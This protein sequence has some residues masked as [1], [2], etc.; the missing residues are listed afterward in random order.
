[1]KTT[2]VKF[3]HGLTFFFIIALQMKALSLVDFKKMY[4]YTKV[5]LDITSNGHQMLGGSI[6][7]YNS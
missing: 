7:Y 3:D 2:L 6:T 5:C 4:S 1:M